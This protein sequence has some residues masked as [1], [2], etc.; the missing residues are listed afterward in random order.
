LLDLEFAARYRHKEELGIFLLRPKASSEKMERQIDHV[1]DSIASRAPA[2][3][4]L[5]VQE[6]SVELAKAVKHWAL[7]AG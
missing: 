5:E 1:I 7:K 2:N 6:H 4:Y 3:L